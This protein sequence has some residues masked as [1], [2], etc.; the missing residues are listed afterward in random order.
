[1]FGASANPVNEQYSPYELD[2]TGNPVNT[3]RIK[4]QNGK[5]YYQKRDGQV[6]LETYAGS[7]P[8]PYN[9]DQLH[10]SSSGY[11]RLGECIVG[12]IISH[13]GN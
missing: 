12:A 10:C 3:T 5:A 13:Y 7:A 6:V 11:A 8:F 4:Y 2:S 1:M 9:S